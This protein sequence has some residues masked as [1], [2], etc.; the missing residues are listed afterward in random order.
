M[1]RRVIARPVKDV[2]KWASKSDQLAQAF[3]P[4]ATEAV[5]PL[6]SGKNSRGASD[7]SGRGDVE[8]SSRVAIAANLHDLVGLQAFAQ[9]PPAAADPE[10]DDALL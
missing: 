1:P 7:E 6:A 9:T 3:A 10:A 2:K 8:P 5:D 4:F